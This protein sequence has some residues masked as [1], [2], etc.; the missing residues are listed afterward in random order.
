MSRRRALLAG[1][2]SAALLIPLGLSPALAATGDEPPGSTAVPLVR[3]EGL[4]RPT[5][6]QATPDAA[7]DT[8][9]IEAEGQITA[10]VELDAPSGIETVEA[11]GDT[12]AVEAAA[13]DV[14]AIAADV[15]PADVR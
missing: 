11:G 13:A 5:G 4:T 14:E 6:E 3:P 1:V 12:A 9:L 7:L 2:A 15:V 8:A 10:F